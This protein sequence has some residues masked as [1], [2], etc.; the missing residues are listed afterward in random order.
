MW[1]WIPA[2]PSYMISVLLGLRYGEAKRRAH[3][4]DHPHHIPRLL[5]GLRD[6]RGI[7]SVKHAP[8]RR[9]QDWLSGSCLPHSP[10]P[11]FLPRVHQS[12]SPAKRIIFPTSFAFSTFQLFNALGR[13]AP[14]ANS[15][16]I[17]GFFLTFTNWPNLV[18]Y[19]YSCYCL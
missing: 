11:H 13:K 5:G 18:N 19:I 17:S 15:G 14:S 6:D 16:N 2:S 12:V 7:L 10:R 9:R 8:K 4:H 3:D 1:R